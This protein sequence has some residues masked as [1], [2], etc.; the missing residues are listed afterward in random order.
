MNQI[1][2]KDYV[3]RVEIG[4]FESERGATQR[5]RFNVILTLKSKQKHKSDNLEDVISYEIIINAIKKSLNGP[6]LNLLETLAEDICEL[7][8]S[9]EQTET[10]EIEIEKL[11][12]IPGSLGVRLIRGPDRV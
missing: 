6:R 9:F 11:D 2:V 10:I 5:L 1:F 7:C 3:Q 8:L 4:A 12:R